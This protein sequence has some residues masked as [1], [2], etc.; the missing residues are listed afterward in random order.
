MENAPK[1]TQRKVHP[2]LKVF[3]TVL[4]ILLLLIGIVI[5]F[6]WTKLDKIQYAGEIPDD[7]TYGIDAAEISD[8]ALVDISGLEL[9][10][11]APEISDSEII[12]SESVTNVLILGTDERTREFSTNARSDSMIIASINWKEN[13]IKLVSLERGMGV[14]VAGTG[15]AV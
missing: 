5:G 14:P 13:T 11:T 1:D 10:E 4:I 3:L 6:I 9:V 8:D 2:I 15:R 7:V 12:S